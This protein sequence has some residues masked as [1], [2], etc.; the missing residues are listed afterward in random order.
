MLFVFAHLLSCQ[1][2][3]EL[4]QPEPQT[5]RFTIEEAKRWFEQNQKSARFAGQ[6]KK[7]IWEDAT[8]QKGENGQDLVIVP[9]LS[10]E[11]QSGFSIGTDKNGKKKK[12][13]E[14]FVSADMKTSFVFSKVNNKIE[15]LQMQLL[16]DEEAGAKK[17]KEK[18]GSNNFDGYLLLFD[19]DE[20]L[21]SGARFQNG[22]VVGTLGKE[23]KN[24]RSSYVEYTVCVDFYQM[25]SLSDG[26]ILS[27]WTLLRTECTTLII[28]N[29]SPTGGSATFFTNALNGS[30]GGGGGSGTLSQMLSLNFVLDFWNVLNVHEKAYFSQNPWLLPGAALARLEAET[31]VRLFYCNNSDDGNWNAFKHALWA[32]MLS[33]HLG[34]FQAL[35]ITDIHEQNNNSG[36]PYTLSNEMDFHNNQLGINTYKGIRNWLSVMTYSLRLAAITNVILSKINDGFGQRVI[37]GANGSPLIAPTTGADRCR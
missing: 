10:L 13:E 16:F 30:I 14:A 8:E 31:A 27:S 28:E 4:P 37:T 26:T 25:T 18:I 32:A 24:G 12:P 22:K 5:S 17:R 1:P 3:S 19:S 33:E 6:D 2:D 11:N 7:V 29:G 15:V 23:K 20:K 21:I 9:A 34:P 35:I 36:M